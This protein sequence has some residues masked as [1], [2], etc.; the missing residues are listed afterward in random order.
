VA[1]KIE[2]DSGHKLAF[3][4]TY[5]VGLTPMLGDSRLRQAKI[6]KRIR[7]VDLHQCRFGDKQRII[8][9]RRGRKEV[10]CARCQ[11]ISSLVIGNPAAGRARGTPQ[12]QRERR[13]YMRLP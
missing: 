1:E 11:R 13:A 2:P 10:F 12:D 3:G 9:D 4:T 8:R 5:K 6:C 7:R